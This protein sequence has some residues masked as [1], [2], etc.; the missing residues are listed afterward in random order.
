[1]PSNEACSAQTTGVSPNSAL[2]EAVEASSRPELGW[3][4]RSRGAG[5]GLELRMK[6][7]RDPA[8]PDGGKNSNTDLD[9]VPRSRSRRAVAW[10]CHAHAD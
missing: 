4:D 8:H 3:F 2:N 5:P 7:D 6:D 10:R 9:A 1:M